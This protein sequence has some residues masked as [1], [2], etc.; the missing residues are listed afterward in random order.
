MKKLFT[1]FFVVMLF[2]V[3]AGC[4]QTREPDIDD[5][6]VK[7]SQTE[8][9]TENYPDVEYIS[10]RSIER[11]H[12]NSRF[13]FTFSFKDGNKKYIKC[14]ATVEMRISNDAG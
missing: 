10:D 9:K 13:V 5:G 12:A 14:P 8:K 3:F 6:N 1:V 7:E 11:D 2:L 4:D